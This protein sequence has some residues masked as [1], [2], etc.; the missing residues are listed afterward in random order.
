MSYALAIYTMR[1]IMCHTHLL[2]RQ[3]YLLPGQNGGNLKSL[4]TG[5]SSYTV[6]FWS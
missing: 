6:Q 5:V 3:A 1:Y 4:V 2:I